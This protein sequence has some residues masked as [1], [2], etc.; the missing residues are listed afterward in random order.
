[1]KYLFSLIILCCLQ[2]GAFA[3]TTYTISG[4]VTDT[5]GKKL[6]SATVFIAGTEQATMTDDQGHFVFYRL[7]PGNYQVVVNMLG[8][9]Y[10]KKAIALKDKP[11]VVDIALGEKQIALQEVKIN[12]TRHLP[13]PWQIKMFLKV[14]IGTVVFANEC[15][16]LNPEILRFKEQGIAVLATTSDFLIVENKALGYRIKYLLRFFQYVPRENRYFYDGDYSFEPMTGTPEQQLVW[17][18]NRKIAYLGSFMHYLR[19]LYAQTAQKEGFLT[20]QVTTID[21]PVMDMKPAPIFSEQI[22][23]RESGD[24]AAFKFGGNWFYVVYD[25]KKA[26]AATEVVVTNDK[27]KRLY[28]PEPH[29][30]VFRIGGK[31]DN[32]GSL[33]EY[34]NITIRGWWTTKRIAW[35]LPYEYE[36]VADDHPVN[37]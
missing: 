37:K 2:I 13:K 5:T 36:Y 15:K 28:N 31:F 26:A 12:D 1:M 4:T 7:T 16:V 8:Y 3:Q 22:I 23:K 21:Y 19:S 35:Q 9:N 11:E 30:S 34:E 32:R 24:Q 20:Y 27:D 18:R 10:V 29:G 25:P 33:D 6:Q 17:E 14:F